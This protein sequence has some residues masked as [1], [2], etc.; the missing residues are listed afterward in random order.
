MT[1]LAQRDAGVSPD[2]GNGDDQHFAARWD[3]QREVHEGVEGL[4]DLCAAA[5]LQK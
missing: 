3:G 4:G 1:H 5:V 2:Q